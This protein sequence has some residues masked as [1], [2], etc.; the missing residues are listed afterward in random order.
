MKQHITI[1]QFKE[2]DHAAR[3]RLRTWC[4]ETYPDGFL[5]RGDEEDCTNPLLSIGQM[6]DFLD[7]NGWDFSNDYIGRGT[8][9]SSDEAPWGVKCDIDFEYTVVIGTHAEL[10][11]ALWECV[12]EVLSSE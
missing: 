10:C 7:E 6:I 8:P 1:E 12:K 5:N 11:D 3:E 2:L 9:M 4:F